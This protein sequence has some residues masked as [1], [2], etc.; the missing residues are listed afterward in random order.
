VEGL[1]VDLYA[2]TSGSDPGK[3]IYTLTPDDQ[4][5]IF[6]LLAA[7]KF[8][9][10]VTLLNVQL[11]W[12]LLGRVGALIWAVSAETESQA[13]LRGA[14]FAHMAERNNSQVPPS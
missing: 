8:V 5:V 4:R 7:Q 10:A 12:T 14:A 6:H 11:G 9:E 1:G 13:K 3:G 2:R